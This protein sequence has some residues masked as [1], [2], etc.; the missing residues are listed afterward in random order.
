MSYKALDFGGLY[1][2]ADCLTYA[3][4]GLERIGFDVSSAKISA[5]VLGSCLLDPGVIQF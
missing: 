3:E 1:T 4:T 2:L 5:G